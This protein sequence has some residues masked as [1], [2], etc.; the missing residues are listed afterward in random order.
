MKK[1][2][3]SE[4]GNNYINYRIKQSKLEILKAVGVSFITPVIFVALKTNFFKKQVDNLMVA[5]VIGMLLLCFFTMV[6][7]TIKRVNT[8]Q[9]LVK[10]VTFNAEDSILILTMG[11]MQ[12][13]GLSKNYSLFEGFKGPEKMKN[14]LDVGFTYRLENYQNQHVFYFISGYFENWDDLKLMLS[15]N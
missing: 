15:K 11:K 8:L 12:F 9:W 2:Q 4:E 7:M 10:E 1:Y 3:V 6:R 5:L 14:I 13:N